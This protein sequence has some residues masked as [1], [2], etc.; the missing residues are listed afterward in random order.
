MIKV[1]SAHICL[2]VW[3]EISVEVVLGYMQ[4]SAGRLILVEI[5]KLIL[6]KLG[7]PEAVCRWVIHLQSLRCMTLGAHLHVFPKF[8]HDSFT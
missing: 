3:G 2:F 4:K 5:I 6:V 1:E 8:L 7:I